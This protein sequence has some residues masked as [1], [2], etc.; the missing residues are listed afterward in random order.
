M[1]DT[2]SLFDGHC[3][4]YLT[5]LLPVR[6]LHPTQKIKLLPNGESDVTVARL[7]RQRLITWT[8]HQCGRAAVIEPADE[9]KEILDFAKTI[10][11]NHR[12]QGNE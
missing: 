5:K 11:N 7:P 10:T 2:D 8:L 12:K 3:D 4:A 6:P 9:R 1:A